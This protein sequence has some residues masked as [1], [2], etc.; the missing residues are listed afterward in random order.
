MKRRLHPGDIVALSG[1]TIMVGT[2]IVS[3]LLVETTIGLAVGIVT[4]AML[5]IGGGIASMIASVG[6]RK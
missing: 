1:V 2:L 5:M 3:N 4:G 6:Q